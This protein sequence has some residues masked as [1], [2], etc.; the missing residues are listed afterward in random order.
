MTVD[1]NKTRL[2]VGDIKTPLFEGT[3]ICKWFVGEKLEEGEF[4]QDMLSIA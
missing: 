1:F 4:K 2:N 3:I